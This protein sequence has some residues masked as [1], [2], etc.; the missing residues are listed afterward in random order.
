MIIFKLPDLGEGLPDAIIREWYIK[1]GDVVKVDQPLVAMETAKA[2]V[3]VPAPYA[4]T[5]EKLFG[6]VGDTI[7]TG[8]P[9]IGFEGE[10]AAET[11]TDSGT[12]VGAI[13]Q[14]GKIIQE[15]AFGVSRQ[16]SHSGTQ[17][18]KA[19]PAVRALAKKLG[20]DLTTLTPQGAR[21]TAAEVRQ[22]AH[23]S[24]PSDASLP[25]DMQALTPARR[26]MVMSMKK[27]QQEVVPVTLV[28]DADIHAWPAK[29][30]TTLR[31]LRAIAAAC[32]QEPM[33]NASFDGQHM[34]YR[35]NQ[36]INVGIAVDTEHGLYVPVLKDIA[37]RDDN[38]LREQINQFKQQ[39]RDKSIAQADLHG[40]TI[41]LSN[42]GAIAGRYAS[43]I[44]VPPMV[45]IIG[46]GRSRDEVVAIDNKPAIHKMMPLSITVDHRLIT[47]G[48]AARFLK[49]LITTLAGTTQS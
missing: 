4:G 37:K 6:E 5:I 36:A 21:I 25:E 44:I 14:S 40:A 22:A 27:S 18:I 1:Q 19:T 15:T 23:Q 41:M 42:F 39:A 31:L 7:E 34:A 30:D 10:G 20:V 32:Q 29:T 16:S 35:L 46:V 12:V 43:P 2:L 17:R 9:L 8:N 45:A 47:G 38:D 48:E 49:T 28:D 13:E 24:N 33:L 3:D 11:K 26:A